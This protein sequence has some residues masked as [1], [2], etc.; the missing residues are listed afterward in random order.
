M[1]G[2]LHLEKFCLCLV[3]YVTRFA[4]LLLVQLHMS[5]SFVP[6]CHLSLASIRSWAGLRDWTLPVGR[7]PFQLADPE[8]SS[9]APIPPDFTMRLQS[10]GIL[11]YFLHGFH[12]EVTL[13]WV[14]VLDEMDVHI[15]INTVVTCSYA[16]H[17]QTKC[18]QGKC[19]L[20]FRL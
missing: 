14:D 16:N 15:S 11:Q 8:P 10:S 3:A 4:S 7:C 12:V 19:G 2:Y 20:G 5:A 6:F 13:C 17:T 18:T 1:I 9:S